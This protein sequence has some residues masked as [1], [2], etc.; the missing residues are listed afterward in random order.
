M[1]TRREV[2]NEYDVNP[3]SGC[4]RSPGKFE[5]EQ[6][7]APIVYGW[8]L[9]GDTGEHETDDGAL[10]FRLEDQDACFGIPAMFAYVVLKELNEGFITVY[11]TVD[12]P[13]DS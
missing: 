3:V 13:E 9:D 5:G 12:L 4:I 7:Y 11:P 10:Y 6:W 8:M 2:E 1:R